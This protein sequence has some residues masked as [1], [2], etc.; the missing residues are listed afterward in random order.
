M[1]I[2]KKK[3]AIHHFFLMGIFSNHRV[4][5]AALVALLLSFNA[6]A[7]ETGKP[8]SIDLA[9]LD[10]RGRYSPILQSPTRE[11][12]LAYRRQKVAAV[13]CPGV[14]PADY[15]PNDAIYTKNITDNDKWTINSVF[16]LSNP[17]LVQQC[18]RIG[19]IRQGK[20]G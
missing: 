4:A 2:M 9:G 3:L 1:Q 11:E 13:Q 8:L 5:V 6:T 18:Q 17:Q 20:S 14:Y 16:Y 19:E 12:V 7:Q 15:Q 10:Q